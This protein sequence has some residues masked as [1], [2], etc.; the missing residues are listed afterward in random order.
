MTMWRLLASLIALMV[1]GCDA[2]DPF[3]RGDRWHPTGANAANL[4]VMARVPSDLARG[5]RPDR[6]N[7][8]LATAA[9][10]RLRED[11]VRPL[12]DSGLAQVTPVGGGAPASPQAP[13]ANASGAAPSGG[14][15]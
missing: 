3:L 13:A 2:T 15:N 12:P 1:A 4:R 10:V 14:A 5:A 8:D 9:V 7:G 11:R 6:S